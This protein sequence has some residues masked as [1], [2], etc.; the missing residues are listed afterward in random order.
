M[1]IPDTPLYI[2]GVN[3]GPH[4]GSAAL[5]REGKLVAMAEQERFSRRRHAIGESPASAVRACLAQEGIGLDSVAKIA[6]GWN[7]PRLAEIEGIDF[8]EY[9]L[10]SWLLGDQ[11]GDLSRLPGI[12]YIDHHYAHAASAFYTSGMKEAAIIVADGRGE[13]VSTTLA[14]GTASGIDVIRTW[15]TDQSLGHFY[16]WAAEW[17]GLGQWGTGK[18]MGLAAYGTARQPMPVRGA[19]DGY[20]ITGCAVGSAP[21]PYH[22]ALMRS[23]LRAQFRAGNFP[24][25]QG[26][27]ADVM[28]HADFAASAQHALDDALV[29]LTRYARSVTG[30]R[31]LAVAGGVALNCTANGL[32]ARSGAFDEVWI[33]PVPDDAGVSLGAALAVDRETRGEPGPGTRLEH[34]LWGPAFPSPGES[35][36][37]DL[38]GVSID[39]YADDE[40]AEAVS[41]HLAE[42][43]VVGWW[44][45]RSEIGPRALGARSILCDPR[46]RAAHAT[47]NK[48]K[49]RESWRP[50]SPAVLAEAADRLFAAPLPG[51]ADF[52]LA[53]WPVK[54]GARGQVPAAVHV[55]G[56]TRPQAVH[57]G[58]GRYRAV[59]EAFRDRTGI[60]A[61]LNTSFNFQGE[62]MVLSPAEAIAGFR[63]SQLDVLVL[64]DIVV[65][66]EIG[67]RPEPSARKLRSFSFTPWARARTIHDRISVRRDV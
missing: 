9:E 50:L 22:F 48:L 14:V 7:A 33:P 6:I 10:L 16:G 41:R 67:R 12:R 54:D 34:A 66:K 59:I 49:G 2:L 15:A 43:R 23:R 65:R 39:R 17:A 63:T 13:D 42:G 40:L 47:V 35:L 45:G 53:T 61:I 29:S 62:P 30:L 8:N 11:V 51:I 58:Q 24:F 38:T 28:A 5:L 56:T 25:S 46:Q 44:Q 64:D 36:P 52:M 60:A 26:S 55:D 37:S 4:D 27:A 57:P 20:T 3:P 1:A 21:V 32:L 31:S 18:L 19:A